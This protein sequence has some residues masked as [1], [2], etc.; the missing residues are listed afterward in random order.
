MAQTNP[1]ILRARRSYFSSLVFVEEI[2]TKITLLRARSSDPHVNPITAV[3]KFVI[4][5]N[6]T[7]YNLDSCIQWKK[8]CLE[9]EWFVGVKLPVRSILSR[10]LADTR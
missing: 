7:E 3:T 1:F 8:N 2:K 9:A 10:L 4:L 6:I 5:C